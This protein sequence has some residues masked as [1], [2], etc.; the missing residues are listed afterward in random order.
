MGIPLAHVEAGLRSFDLTMPE[1]QNRV[2]T[3][4]LSDV[5]L[6]PSIDANEN[7]AREGVPPERV[8]F[9]GN[10]VIDS[11]ITHRHEAIFDRV[12]ARFHLTERA[13]AVATF[14]RPSNVDDRRALSAIVDA[15]ERV[16]A[17]L[18]VVFPV[19]PRTEQRMREFG[20][21]FRSPRVHVSCPLG[22]LD[23]L[24][25][26][27]H[28]RL[29]ITDSGGLQEE[30]VYLGVPCVTVRSTTERPL[31]LGNGANRL[32]ASDPDAILHG[33]AAA[34]VATARPLRP[35]LWD[36]RAAHRIVDVLERVIP[37]WSASSA[38]CP[39]LC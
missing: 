1:E 6:T 33:V 27:S 17:Q 29:V 23:F 38:R 37:T 8:H 4:R 19:H 13:Y 20:V 39:S 36:G 28:A 31:T 35:E 5:L 25:L 11:L 12:A 26:A 18:P 3:D 30:S 21:A 32:V 14:H 7:L 2:T 34:L 22:Y 24:S 16:G 9:V 15:I 10:V